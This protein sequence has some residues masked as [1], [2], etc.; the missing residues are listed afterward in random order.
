MEDLPKNRRNF[1]EV[2]RSLLGRVPNVGARPLLGK[3]TREGGTS[4]VLKYE[5]VEVNSF[6]SLWDNSDWI[7]FR[8]GNEWIEIF[9][10]PD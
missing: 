8:D 9:Q 3:I 10:I 2:I 4:I 6:Q 7:D 1:P 5:W